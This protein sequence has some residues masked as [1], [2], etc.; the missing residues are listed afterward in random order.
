MN[1]GKSLDIPF[2]QKIPADLKQ[3]I[4][5]FPDKKQLYVPVREKT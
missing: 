5:V 2:I 3:P 4:F 1:T